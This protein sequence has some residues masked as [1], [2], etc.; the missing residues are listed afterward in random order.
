L[1]DLLIKEKFCGFDIL[2]GKNQKSKFFFLPNIKK[3][4]KLNFFFCQKKKK[5]KNIDF[6]FFH[7]NLNL[8]LAKF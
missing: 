6:G 8:C 5:K 4:K 3:K 7:K 2:C 1:I